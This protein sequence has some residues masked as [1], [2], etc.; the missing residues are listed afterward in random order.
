MDDRGP[1]EIVV[2]GRVAQRRETIDEARE[3]AKLE[4]NANPNSHVS[5]RDKFGVSTP[6]D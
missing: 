4:K 6:Q 5:V 3:A 1:F 2:H